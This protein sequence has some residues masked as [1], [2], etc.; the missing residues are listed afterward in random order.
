MD[1]FKAM[2]PVDLCAADLSADSVGTAEKRG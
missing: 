1:F 2:P